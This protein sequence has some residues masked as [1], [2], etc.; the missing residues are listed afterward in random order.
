MTR[1]LL[2]SAAR[3]AFYR[4]YRDDYSREMMRQRGIDVSGDRVYTDLAFARAVPGSE[5]VGGQDVA[6]GIMA[7][8]GSN[9]DRARADELYAAYI[10]GMK[11]FVRWLVDS[12]RS[13][14]LIVGDANGSD[15][16]ALQEILAD[17]RETRPACLDSQVAAEPVVT[18]ADVM[19]Q[20]ARVDSVVAIRFHNVICGLLLAKPTI[21]VSYAPKHDA[22][23]AAVGLPEFAESANWLNSDQLIARFQELERRSAELRARLEK[24]N[25]EKAVLLDEQFAALTAALFSPSTAARPA[26]RRRASWPLGSPR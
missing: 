19:H 18:F 2:N 13:V 26:G 24:G 23:M 17:L 20:V 5:A 7:Y 3:L 16:A 4:S 9:A 21:A 25:T 15:E 11:R 1:M 12:G 8:R 6:V 10:E 14:R 22:L